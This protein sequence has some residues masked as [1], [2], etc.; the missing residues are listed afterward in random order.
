MGIRNGIVRV[1]V[2]VACSVPVTSNAAPTVA[3]ESR[4][5]GEIIVPLFVGTSGP[6]RFLLDTGSS[7]S[8]I[9]RRLADQIEARPVAK[10]PM[11]TVT[12]LETVLVVRLP[13]VRVGDAEVQSL[14]ATSL[15]DAALGRFGDGI[16]GVLGQD[17]LARFNFTLDYRGGRVVWGDEA[18]HVG[19]ARLQLEPADGR[20]LLA[21]PQ[22][23]GCGCRLRFVPDSGADGV[24]LFDHGHGLRLATRQ[25]AAEFDVRSLIGASTAAGVILDRLQVGRT[26]LRDQSAALLRVEA[27]GPDRGDGLLPLHLFARVYFNNREAYVSVEEYA[28]R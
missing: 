8:S 28:G 24:V 22:E 19:G 6:Y 14:D 27:A 3:F 9:R 7:H 5:P 18:G 20:F 4:R 10:A 26:I 11:V 2:L 15:P 17:F 12:G 1:F 23:R 25:A 21:L 13:G 16:D